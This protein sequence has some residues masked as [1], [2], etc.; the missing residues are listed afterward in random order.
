MIIINII[1]IMMT[2]TTTI[3]PTN[4]NKSNLLFPLGFFLCLPW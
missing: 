2:I 4:L 3:I 1:I